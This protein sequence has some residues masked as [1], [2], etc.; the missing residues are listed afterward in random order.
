MKKFISII[1]AILL[2]VAAFAQS[3]PQTVNFSATV[4]DADNQ[5]L[6]NS[7]ITV[8][9]TV[10]EGGE[11]GTPVYCAM[12]QTTT[13][14]NGFMSF[15][16]NRDVYAY[17]SNVTNT[18]FDEIPW[19]N[20]NYWLYVEYQ[21]QIGAPFESLGYLEITS[22]FYAFAA[23]RAL[24]AQR[25]EGFD[26]DV[27]NAQDGDILVYN[28]T[29]HKWEARHVDNIGGG[30]ENT[31]SGDLPTNWSNVIY[32]TRPDQV[33]WASINGNQVTQ[34]SNTI[35]G[36]A[37]VGRNT[38]TA[39]M[40]ATTSNCEGFVVVTSDAYTTE[41]ALAASY[42]AGTVVTELS[43]PY[44]YH[45]KSFSPMTFISKVDGTYVLVK[46]VSADCG[47]TSGDIIGTVLGFLY[48][49]A[50]DSSTTSETTGT[51]NGYDWVDLG[52]PSGTKWATCNVG[53][54]TPE[55]YGNYYAWGE[56]TTKETYSWDTYRYYDGSNLTKYTG[57]DGLATLQSSDDAATANWGSGWRMPTQT[58]M[59]EL[60][61]NCTVTWTTQNGVNGRLFT[62]S[63]GN[64]I[65]LPAAGYRYDSELNGAGSGGYVW[66]G[67]L[68]S[69]DTGGAWG[70]L[71]DSDGCYVDIGDRYYGLTVRAV[72]Q[73]QN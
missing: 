50:E 59:R 49:R 5:L 62:G 3:V 6:A 48:K 63:N 60:I 54:T 21:A 17:C 10:Y 25:L 32:L 37:M 19:G 18:P 73:S 16:L 8:R 1:I 72:C 9:L 71:F 39:T 46:V 23:D 24:V 70:L 22:G 26:I 40:I 11:G 41:E 53:A 35:M 29:T 31:Q 15:Q 58:E 28:G 43:V 68:Y 47:N 66:S 7:P 4:R 56:T 44:D 64:S 55:G 51:L 34:D 69:D 33:T 61:D 57:S 65:F 67:S 45:A 2:G 30:G 14:A 13:N 12:H 52:L 38:S 36:V 20:G 27:T 42:T